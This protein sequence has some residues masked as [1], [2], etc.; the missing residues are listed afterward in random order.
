MDAYRMDPSPE[1]IDGV[2]AAT[3]YR[4]RED[5]EQSLVQLLLQFLQAESVTLFRLLRE[6]GQDSAVPRLTARPGRGEQTVITRGFG[7][8]LRLADLPLW[9]V[10][11]EERFAQIR[12]CGGHSFETVFPVS[13]ES[14]DVVA[15]IQIL[16]PKAPDARDLYL[17]GGILQIIRNHLALIDY[18]ERDTLTG[19]LNRKT[20]E[21]QFDKLRASTRLQVAAADA[22]GN[23]IGLVDID[24]F[25][26]INDRFGHVFGDEVLLL[27]SQIIQRT[28][29]GVDH[30]YRFGGE[31]FVILLKDAPEHATAAAIERLRVAVEKHP[32][33]QVGTVTISAGWTRI[34]PQDAPTNAVERA[35]AALY[36][37]KRSGRNRVCHHEELIA[38]GVLAAANTQ[39]GPEIEL[40]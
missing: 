39:D 24:R 9:R 10:S 6:G 16:G 1:L 27:V 5:I 22:P 28:F 36:H 4:D 29:R 40:F 20:F 12:D 8:V 17:V 7:E 18:G 15:I 34:R 19:L 13:G 3:L 14:D 32:F 26:A 2:A 38:T 37:A 11:I 23:W 30:V 35:D 31:E 21:T 33:P 25:K